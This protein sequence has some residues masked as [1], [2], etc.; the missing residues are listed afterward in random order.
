MEDHMR[1]PLLWCVCTVVSGSALRAQDSTRLVAEGNRWYREGQYEKAIT[2]YRESLGRQ[3]SP[4]IAQFNLGVALFRTNQL[5][6]A[7]KEFHEL[8]KPGT[9]ATLQQRASY[10]EGVALARDNKLRESI[11]AFK[12]ALLLDPS[13]EDAR[14]NLQ[15]AIEAVKPPQQPR[16]QPRQNQQ[17]KDRKSPEP[18]PPA[19]K[20]MMEQWL[21]SLR[22][23]EQEVQRKMM[24]KSR[25]VSQPEKDW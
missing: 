16:E 14:Y 6:P 23:K 15:K 20:K 9:P 19:N 17:Q 22:Q 13:D 8:S 5:Q 7:A 11:P 21:Q 1:Y 10:N 12:K 2:H 3:Q 25:S 4:G 18:P 24:N